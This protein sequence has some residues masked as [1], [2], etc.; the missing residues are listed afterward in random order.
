[1]SSIN[2]NGIDVNYPVPGVNN[3]SQGFRNNFAAIKT[4]LDTAGTEIT[5]LQNKAVLKAA[6]A[7][8]VI[9]NDMANTLISNAS[10]R[11]FR[12][13]TYNL[14]NALSG[15]VIVNA[16]L[17]DVQYGNISNNISLQFSSWAPV[18]TEQKIT[19]TLG[20]SNREAIISF[21]TETVSNNSGG[22]TLLE[23]YNIVSNV[24]SVSFPHDIDI[25][26]YELRTT[27]CGNTIYI[28][29][30]NR[31]FHASQ[32]IER[33]PPSTGQLGDTAG[34]I[35]VDPSI[36]QIPITGVNTNPILTTSGNTDQLYTGLPIVFTGTTL[37]ANLVI[38]NTYY[39][40]NVVSSNTF[41]VSSTIDGAN[42]AIG[43]NSTGTTMFANPIT[44]MYLAT[45]DYDSTEYEKTV[46]ATVPTI[47]L[48]GV[49]IANTAGGFTCTSSTLPLVVG[50]PLTISGTLGGTG[51]ITGYSNPTTYY[52]RATNGST[53]FQLSATYGG[54]A[55]TTTAGTPTGLTYTVT[56]N[57]IT[58]NN[59]TSLVTN[60]PVIFSG[61]LDNSFTSNSFIDSNTVYYIKTFPN[62]TT[63]TVSKTRYNGI[64]GPYYDLGSWT[65]SAAVTLTA[66]VGSDIWRR[67]SFNPF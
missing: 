22:L 47:T 10:T 25:I 29:P 11:S 9:N 45:G 42:I 26:S 27:D 31:P 1:M 66:Y 30:L 32:I 43:A 37:A 49:T 51:S 67:T 58:V 35:C 52:I 34:T 62:S 19:L 12:A 54:G 65:S 23:N 33:T 60:A 50:Q 5:D 39:V 56:T 64:A 38:G 55:I 21:P 16:S 2:T 28:T 4:N 46:T 20:T 17:G 7:N 61:E 40:R 13:T 36:I 41:T 14:G 44:Y 63:M 59:I 6:L 57:S 15:T 18:G 48:S 8:T 3:N 53:S 24:S